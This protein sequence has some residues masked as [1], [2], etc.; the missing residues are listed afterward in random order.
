MFHYFLS[1][2]RGLNSSFISSV[3]AKINKKQWNCTSVNS[4][5]NNNNN[6]KIYLQ[7]VALSMPEGPSLMQR[8]FTLLLYE[9]GLFNLNFNWFKLVV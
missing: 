7:K 1:D 5:N 9:D 6:N 8:G 3:I 4:N 2:K